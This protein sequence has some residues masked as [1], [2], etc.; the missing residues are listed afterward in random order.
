MLTHRAPASPAPPA[1][2]SAPA[3]RPARVRVRVEWRGPVVAM[4]RVIVTVVV[5]R[6]GGS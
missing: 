4:A 5:K 1:S 3:S 2:S 6:K